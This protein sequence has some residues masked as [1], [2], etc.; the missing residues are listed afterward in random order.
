[1]RSIFPIYKLTLRS[2]FRERVA[3][4]MLVL[5]ALVLLLLPAGLET[6]GTIQGALR[7][8]IRYSLGFST[9]LL[10]AMT[11]WVSCASIAGDISSKRLQMV[12]TKPVHRTEIWWGKWL[13]VVTLVSCLAL[14]CGAVTYL[15]IQT[16]IQTSDLSAEAR[17]VVFSQQVTSRRPVDPVTVDL[18]PEAEELARQ[19][20]LNGAIPENVPMEVVIPEMERFLKVTNNAAS[21]GESVSWTFELDAPLQEGETFQLAYDYD[22]A[23]MGVTLV[24]GAWRIDVDGKEGVRI[25]ETNETPYGEKVIPVE[26]GTALAGAQYLTLTYENRSESSG[27]VFFKPHQGVRLYF[28][29]GGFLLN[30]VRALILIC[31]LL[32]LLAAIGV[33]AGSIFSLPV[34]CYVSAVVLLLQAFSGTVEEAVEQG[35]P[36]RQEEQGAFSR[37]IQQVQFKVFEGI[38]VVIQPLQMENPLGRVSRGIEIPPSEVFR[39]FL[40]RFTPVVLLIS[41]LGTLAFHRREIGEAT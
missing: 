16:M 41:G 30:L 9:F 40:L 18:T 2:I 29:T 22:G 11:I 38:L 3:L 5:L 8:H 6:D 26:V 33:S 12:L 15:R 4:S 28:T 7:M 31:G 21:A 14:I 32:S 19:Q 20:I 17:Q 34:A 10:A 35:I 36:P 1:M 23:A 37:A 25:F 24:P 27:R 13:A 39:I